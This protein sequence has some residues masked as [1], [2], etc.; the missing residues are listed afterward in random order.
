MPD[1]PLAEDLDHVVEHIR[2]LREDLRGARIF[3]TGGTGFIGCWLL[4][5][6]AWANERLGLGAQALV[7]TRDFEA[8]QKKAPH[9]ANRADIGFH[10]GDVRNFEFPAGR[11]SHVIHAATEASEKLNT[12]NPAL[13]LDTILAG[14]GQ[15]LNFSAQCGARQF[16]LTSSGAVYGKQPAD[17]THISE[18]Y[19]GGPDVCLPRSAYGEGKRVS[20]L[21]CAIRGRSLGIETKIAR[22]FAFV[23]PYL[24]LDTHFAIGNFIRDAMAGGPIIVNGD[25]TAYRSYLYAADLAIWLWWIFL[26]AVGYRPYNVGSRNQ[27]TIAEVA[28][29]VSRALPG[30]VPVSI[31]IKAVPGRPPQRY[32]P[33]TSRAEGEMPLQEWVGLEEAIRR[34]AR[35]H[36]RTR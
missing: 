19:M 12:E 1:N 30:N 24:P 15:V 20:E 35:W 8:F 4:E 23:G 5:S 25:G 3:I 16:L 9:L 26:R 29:A 13:M 14:T 22:C 27:L 31:Q 28:A 10:I 6:F 32:V 21:V 17:L 36:Q 34:T 33:D 11:F 18:D 7:L 2:H